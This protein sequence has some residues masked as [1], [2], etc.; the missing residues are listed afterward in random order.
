MTRSSRQ[1][2]ILNLIAS[3]AIDTQE[4]LCR[5]LRE[6]GFNATQATVSRDIRELGLVKT[7]DSD[8]VYKY[9]TK[10]AAG[11]DI[12][13]RV[14]SVLRDYIVSV[15]AVENTVVVKTL[16]DCAHLVSS[17]IE[18][19]DFPEVVAVVADRATI[20]VLCAFATDAT[21]LTSKLNNIL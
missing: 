14:V 13:G 16:A 4:E 21:A 8:G 6:E 10:K 3:H 11:S 5:L 7:V 2:K 9:A 20:L 1:A 17:A 18:Q 15:V 12:G 19:C